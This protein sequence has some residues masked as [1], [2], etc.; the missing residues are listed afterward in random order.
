MNKI[1][2]KE[3]IEL[4]QNDDDVPAEYQDE[5]FPTEKK[6]YELKYAGKERKEKILSDTMSVPF[7]AIKHFGKAKEGEWVNKLIFGDNLQALKHLLKLKKEGKLRNADGTDGVRLVYIDPPFATKQ[8]FKGNQDQKAYGDKVAGSNFI[9]F[10]RRR[11]ILLKELLSDNGS[12][13]VHLDY[14]S[15]H[16]IK[17]IIDEIF[18][19]NNL[20]NEIIYA[21][22]IQGISRSS[23]ARKHQTILWY[24]KT[25]KYIFKKEKERIVY[26]KPF[27]DTP[28]DKS[29]SSCKDLTEKD[30]ESIKKYLN[31]RKNLPDRYKSKLFNH[32]YSDVLVRDVWD[33]DYTK[34]FISG[35]NEYLGYPTQKSEGLL[36]RI[37]ENASKTGDILLDCFAGSGTTGAVA[38]K[39][40]RRWIMV[41]CGKLAIYTMTKRMLNLKKEIGNKGEPLKHKPFVLYNAGLYDDGKLLEH[42]QKGEYKEFVLELFGC[43]KRDHQI[44]GLDFH[45]TLNNHS[46]MV[47]DKEHYLTKEF[48]DQLHK[49]IGVSIKSDCFIIAPVGIVGFNEDYIKKRDKTYTILRVPNS[50]IAY[51]REKNFTRLDQPRTPDDINQT[52]DAVGFDFIYPPRVKSVYSVSKPKENL[53]ESEYSIKIKDFEPIQLGS[54]I[55]EF[56]DST[57]ESLAMIMIDFDYDGETFQ[58]DKY[59]F[60]SDIAKNDFKISFYDEIG[61]KIMII[62]LDIF[63]NEKKEVL[64][65]KDFVKMS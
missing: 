60:G 2:R 45:G 24:S 48:I 13:M 35:S 8:D 31:E 61:D 53:I 32:Y 21:Y 59:W 16:S 3:I 50:I 43:Q 1:I 52:I 46:V 42:M 20:L 30:I 15:V 5:L 49:T 41:D 19:K 47:F 54:K 12:I 56:K 55:V 44:N 62:Y 10:V 7:Q 38:E 9:E 65:K 36:V 34:P 64:C 39:L 17:L 25:N 57:A 33:G 22:R 29:F 23:Y 27:R 6:E 14:R 40:G 58:M 63:G 26:E 18:G 11:L 4:L 28:I 51:I 37:I